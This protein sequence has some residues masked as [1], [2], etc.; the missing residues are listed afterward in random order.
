M[1]R[2][3]NAEVEVIPLQFDPAPDVAKLGEDLI[4]RY[5]PHLAD[6]NFA[7][8]FRNK[9]QARGGKEIFASAEKCTAKTQAL[10]AYAQPDAN[11]FN[12]CIVVSYEV[13]RE[14]SEKQRSALIDHELSHCYV[15][16]TDEGELVY[17]IR[18]HDIEEF[19]NVARRWGAY[20]SDLTLF[21]SAIN[22]E[23]E[24]AEE[25]PKPTAIADAREKWHVGKDAGQKIKSK[26]KQ[27]V[28]RE[29]V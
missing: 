6:C 19:T 3:R 25:G 9:R 23:K 18:K 2:K 12:F 29:A 15:D 27:I 21:K 16:E 13:W 8:L 7:Y 14:L 24:K 10:V 20:S 11:K 28:V 26:E 4:A 5:H 22:G 1:P 17:S